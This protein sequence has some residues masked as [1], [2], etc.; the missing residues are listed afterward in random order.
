MI[1]EKRRKKK[2]FSKIIKILL[3]L[4]LLIA[5]AILV[6]LK[7]FTIENV[8]IEGNKLYDQEVIQNVVLNDEYSW[9]SLYVFL[10]YKIQDTD[11]VPFV[12][13]MDISIKD[14]H[15]LKIEVYEKGIL[16]YIYIPGIDEN[17]YFDKDGLVVETSSDVIKGIPKIEGI[18][19]DEVVLYEKLPINGSQLRQ[20]L[21]L[22]QTLKR[23]KLVPD[24]IKYGVANAPELK[25]KK[26]KVLIGD[27]E[28]L[29]MK[30]DRLEAIMPSLKGEAGT[31]HLENW[32]EENTN[33][34]FDKKK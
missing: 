31:L 30:V 1:K 14:P 4:I 2:L 17:A 12:D 26:V 5:I 23:K 24:S 15:T 29:T 32:S 21:S 34:V 22:T 28:L 3:V 27:E 25:Y 13:T 18:Q 6:V 33:I 20:M 19:C 8:Q 11:T 16:G 9:N 10:K 7:V